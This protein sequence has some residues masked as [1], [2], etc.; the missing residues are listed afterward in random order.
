MQTPTVPAMKLYIGNQ[1]YSS[2]S[3]RPWLLMRQLALPFETV[4]LRFDFTPG[5]AFY[6]A[7]DGVTPVGRVPVLVEDDG[8][9][10]WDSLAIVE[11]LAER[12]PQAGVWPAEPRARARARSNVAEMHSGFSALRGHCPMN[13]E[14]ELAEV[15][16][17]LWDEQPDLRRDVAR[18]EAMW[19]DA[20]Q[21]SGGPMLFGTFSAADAFFAPV[22]ARLQTYALPAAAETRAYVERVRALPAMQEWT[23]SALA[24]ADFIVED[25]PYRK[26]RN[27]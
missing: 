22:C 26:S 16:R 23:R 8:F 20:L 19:R 2:W 1:N 15:G 6:R 5:S 27:R 7:L 12:F 18:I 25:E 13:L 24:E 11:Y 14:A 9:A 10:V 21:G 17:R 3:L 4:K